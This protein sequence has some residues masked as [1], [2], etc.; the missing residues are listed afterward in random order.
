MSGLTPRDGELSRIRQVLAGLLVETKLIRLSRS[1]ARKYSPDRP[2]APA[3]QPDGGRWVSEGGGAGEGDV[4]PALVG[5]GRWT[6]L[7]S[8]DQ[9]GEDGRSRERTLL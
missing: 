9:A 2:R 4:D 1:L 5:P 6:S 3:G 8:Q 7:A